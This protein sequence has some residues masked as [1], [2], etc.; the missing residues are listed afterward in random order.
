MIGSTSVG[1]TGRV[2]Y[3]GIV[4]EDRAEDSREILV[5]CKD[6]LP[7]AQGSIVPTNQQQFQ[8]LYQLLYLL[9]FKP[10]FLPL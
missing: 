3:D 1:P 4:L 6:I 5:Y 10:L 9:Q 7:L 2:E 8:Q